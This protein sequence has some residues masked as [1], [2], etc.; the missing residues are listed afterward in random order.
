MYQRSSDIIAGLP[1]NIASTAL[2]VKIICQIVN[3][4][5]KLENNNVEPLTE[6][7]LT[8]HLGDVHLYHEESHIN[9]LKEQIVRK[10]YDFPKLEFK[11]EFTYND[12][13]NLKWEDIKLKDYVCHPTIKI[14]MVA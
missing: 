3:T 14:N 6:G 11:R 9:A 2:L 7:N 8:I 5:N 12:L 1:F 4:E 10:C 13:E